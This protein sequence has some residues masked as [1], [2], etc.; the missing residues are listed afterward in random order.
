MNSNS[1]TRLTGW[2]QDRNHDQPTIGDTAMI[3]TAECNMDQG[4]LV[5][6]KEP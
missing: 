3:W 2:S 5:V 6:S 1:S 4:A